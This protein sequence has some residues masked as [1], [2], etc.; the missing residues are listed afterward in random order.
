MGAV[1]PGRS[2]RG[3]AKLPNQI[4]F[5]INNHKSEYNKV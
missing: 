5:I 4:Y 2:R 1:V 3:D